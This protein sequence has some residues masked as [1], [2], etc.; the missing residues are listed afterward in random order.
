MRN[1]RVDMIFP[2]KNYQQIWFESLIV[3]LYINDIDLLLR[4]HYNDA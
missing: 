3:L 2:N 1:M 4:E